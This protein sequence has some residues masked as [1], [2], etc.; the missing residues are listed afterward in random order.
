M[1][2]TD[3]VRAILRPPESEDGT[4]EATSLPSFDGGARI[5]IAAPAP[6]MNVTIRRAA[7]GDV[8]GLYDPRHGGGG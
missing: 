4:P 7:L 5:S 3:W 8:A 2:S 1:A 6:G